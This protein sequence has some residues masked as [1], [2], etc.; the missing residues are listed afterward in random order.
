MSGAN[1]THAFIVALQAMA[2]CLAAGAGLS[3]RLIR[4]ASGLPSDPAS[5]IPQRS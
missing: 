4:R 1:I 3:I 2:V 5:R